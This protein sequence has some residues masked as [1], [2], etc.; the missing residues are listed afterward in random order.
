MIRPFSS[1]TC[2]RRLLIS[3][4]DNVSSPTKTDICSG[5]YPQWAFDRSARAEIASASSGIAGRIVFMAHQKFSLPN[6][7]AVQRP[8]RGPR[9]LQ[10]RYGRGDSQI[11]SMSTSCAWIASASRSF[12]SEV[13][14]VPPGSAI[15]TT[16]ASTADPRRARRRSNAA[17][18]AKDS[19]IACA[20]SQVFRNLFSFASRPACPCR[21]STRTTDGTFGGHSPCS[22]SARI[23]ARESRERS[24][25]RVT[26][27]ESRTSTETYPALR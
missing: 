2:V 23:N 21:H 8:E 1:S 20:T 18:R 10:R 5:V 16:S 14:T 15:A 27:P 25:S 6:D 19:G 22:R 26:P 17:R 13:R 24:A 11:R 9:P 7:T 12:G 3:G 4:G